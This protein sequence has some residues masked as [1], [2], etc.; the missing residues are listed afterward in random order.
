[1]AGNVRELEN[2]LIRAC[3][4]C[5]NGR[6]E[7]EDLDVPAV[8]PAADKP[9]TFQSMKKQ[10]IARFECDYLKRALAAL[11]GAVQFRAP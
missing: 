10:A 4:L 2:A 1:M 7:S 3:Q 5:R 9:S 8:E 11:G 6:I